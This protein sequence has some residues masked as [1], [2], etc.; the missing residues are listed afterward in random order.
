MKWRYCL[1]SCAVRDGNQQH[2]PFVFNNLISEKSANLYTGYSQQY[3]RR[4][5][6]SGRLLGIKVG[7]V[8]LIDKESLDIYFNRALRSK[9]QRFSQKLQK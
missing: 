1:S 8:W 2:F 6:R 7:Q 4:L 5:L 3:I 9:D